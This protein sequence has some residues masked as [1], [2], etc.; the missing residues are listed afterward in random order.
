MNSNKLLSILG[1]MFPHRLSRDWNDFSGLMCGKK[2]NEINRIFICLDFDQ[3][4]YDEVIKFKPDVIFTHHPFIYGKRKE[5][6]A[7]DEE[8]RKLVEKLE[9]NNLPVYS[10]HI[11]FDDAKDGM[12]RALAE[13]LELKDIYYPNELPCLKIGY[14]DKEMDVNEF[15]SFAKEKLDVSYGLL[16]NE[17]K[18]KV[19]KIGIVG[20]AGSGFYKE[21]MKNDCDIYIS[22]D[23]PH[24]IRRAITLDKFNYLDLPH[25]IEKIFIP[26]MKNILLNIDKKFVIKTIDHEKLPKVI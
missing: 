26:T 13:K 1:R 9:A 16:I 8:K 18:K 17:G 2:P 19:K 24:H 15:A 11:N 4:I 14:L 3:S 7:N 22:G 20:G 21:A 10:F 25:E 6:L 12:N 5:V 23:V